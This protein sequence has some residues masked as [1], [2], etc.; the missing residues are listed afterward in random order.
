MNQMSTVPLTAEPARAWGKVILAGEHATVYGHPAVAVGLDRGA[1]ARVRRIEG[2]RSVLCIG[3]SE[4]QETDGNDLA[5]AFSAVL[6]TAPPF[7]LP[8]RV[9]VDTRLPAGSG[10]GSS[11]AIGVAVV[12]A[13]DP[14]ASEGDVLR[15]AMA[16]ERVFHGNPS[17]L[18]ALVAARGGCLYF[19]RG[20][21]VVALTVRREGFLCIGHSGSVASTR[22]MVDSVGALR[23]LSPDSVD[24][25]LA[26]IGA[27]SRSLARA[28]RFGNLREVGRLM[29]ANHGLLRHLGISTPAIDRMCELS[30]DTGALGAKVTGA[31]GGGCVVAL[32]ETRLAAE[33][34][35]LAWRSERFDGFVAPLPGITQQ[36]RA[37]HGRRPR[38][39][40]CSPSRAE[41]PSL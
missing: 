33:A 19:E 12:R 15:R 36:S 37:P 9:E 17:G 16:W 21:R 22:A 1:R 11:A 5:R 28:L 35:L 39:D 2:D 40:A 14:R 30:R 6:E 13:I 3:T 7:A 24:V 18:D 41:R 32:C 29:R 26:A 38:K 25:T 20:K 34:V 27:I 31:G 4:V 23:K 10:L 8:I